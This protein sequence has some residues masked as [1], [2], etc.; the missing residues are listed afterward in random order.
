MCGGVTHNVSVRKAGKLIRPIRL[1]PTNTTPIQRRFLRQIV[2]RLNALNKQIRE[3]IVRED[4]FDLVNNVTTNSRFGFSTKVEK[5]QAFRDWLKDQ[6]DLGLLETDGSEEPGKPWT[7]N[8]I[9]SAYKQAAVKS[10]TQ[11]NKTSQTLDEFLTTAFDSPVATD[12]IELLATRA[13]EQLRGVTDAMAADMNRVFS[14]GI[15]HGKDPYEIARNLTKTVDKISRTR[16]V[17]IARTE[18]VHAYAEGQLDSFEEL[19]VE[20]VG[21][22]AEWS[23]AG[24]GD[25]CDQCEPLEGIIMSVSEARGMIP[26]H[27]N[28]RCA[29]VPALDD[30]KSKSLRGKKSPHPKRRQ[31]ALAKARKAGANL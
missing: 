23:T 29:W 30:R 2:K 10:Y 15:A 24:D 3:L 11:A 14:D 5:T 9:R 7:A 31:K 4:A 13:F 27:P 1:D 6:I 20:E 22:L 18:V 19:G 17:R 8:V 16:A 26:I 28:C 25:V 21:I 12:R